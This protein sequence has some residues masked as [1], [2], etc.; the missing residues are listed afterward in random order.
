VPKT[1]WL[2]IP[3]AGTFAAS[4]FL[5]SID[6]G[7][8]GPH[9]ATGWVAALGALEHLGQMLAHP[10]EE[11]QSLRADAS[12]VMSF[13]LRMSLIAAFLANKW[14]L[15]PAAWWGARTLGSA[16]GPSARRS[17]LGARRKRLDAGIAGI[18]DQRPP[19]VWIL[20]VGR[21]SVR[22]VCRYRAS[23]LA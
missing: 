23:G 17:G 19:T 3:I 6:D 1:Q 14:F 18:R 11:V 9:S 12:P 4:F 13:L 10:I 22:A 7:T 15:G 5:P 16:A 8:R 2:A 21:F 20:P